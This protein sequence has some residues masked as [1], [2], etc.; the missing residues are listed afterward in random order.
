MKTI[1]KITIFIL[2]AG[3]TI[4][5]KGASINEYTRVIKKEFNVN[6]DAQLNVSNKFGGIHCSNWDKN[7]VG[8][9][10]KVVVDAPND[11]AAAKILEK[12]N[13]NFSNS[14]SLVEATTVFDEMNT[15]GKNRFQVEYTINLP[16]SMSLD[17]SNK[18]GDITIN[19]VSG[20]AK[21]N[22]SY[23]SLDVNKLNN[24]DNL[25]DLKFC[26]SAKVRS[27][28]GAVVNLKYST[29]DIDYA[30]S[31]RLDSKYSN[32]NANKIIA[33][34]VSFEGGAVD[35]KNTST[36]DSRCKF[37][38]LDIDRVEQSLSLDIQYGSCSVRNV[39]PDFTNISIKNKY[40]DVDVRLPE[41]AVYNL[42]AALK[43][44]ELSFSENNSNLNYRSVSPTSSE[45]RGVVG[46]KDA[47]PKANVVVRSDYGSVSLK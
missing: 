5:L 11:D 36:M 25:I 17:L 45:Y 47:K 41:S 29:L 20:K 19:E 2:L 44:C 30:G 8:I 15:S 24:S 28:T 31:L 6:P 40:A 46:S 39:G 34:N 14:A 13:V 23:G 9:D 42:D 4:G 16:A 22:L 26:G 35:I 18:F 27:I 21:I 7:L 32:L 37:S 12:I 1:L 3:L 38:D 43:Y 10:V 33:M